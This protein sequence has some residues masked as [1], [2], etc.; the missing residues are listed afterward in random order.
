MEQ[1]GGTLV[2]LEP[3]AVVKLVIDETDTVGTVRETAAERGRETVT[4]DELESERRYRI[5]TE[6]AMGWLPP[7]VDVRTADDAGFKPYGTLASIERVQ[8]SGASG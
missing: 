1:T 7:L 8:R 3:G 6:W 5:E 4:V 2:G